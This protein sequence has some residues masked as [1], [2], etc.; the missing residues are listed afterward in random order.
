MHKIEAAVFLR[1]RRLMTVIKNPVPNMTAKE[2]KE[3]Y[4][5][6]KANNLE[7]H[8]WKSFLKKYRIKNC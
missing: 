5:N 8:G 3:V 7:K 1:R 6:R 4:E 2:L